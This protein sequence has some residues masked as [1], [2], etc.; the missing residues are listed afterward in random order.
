LDKCQK[1]FAKPQLAIAFPEIADAK[2]L[3]PAQF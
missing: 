1:A 3:Y 2:A